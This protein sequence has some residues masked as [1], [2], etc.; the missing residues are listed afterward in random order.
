[1]ALHKPLITIKQQVYEI[2]RD[3]IC[4]GTYPPGHQL[5]ETGL[6]K[7]LGVS[8]SPIREA[9]RQL[10]A[11]GLATDFP[12]RGVFVKAYTT[13]DIKD[14]FDMRILLES[15][16]FERACANITP[17]IRDTLNSC[18]QDLRKFHDCGDLRSYI[19]IDTFLHHTLVTLCGNSL[20][21]DTY[22][23]VYAM[24]QRF[25]EYSLKSPKRFN[26]S[27]T[28]HTEI[29][30]NILDGNF[31]EANRINETHLI[32]AKEAIINYL[33]GSNS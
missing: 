6:S 32:L 14:I 2:L 17:E 21:I 29:I 33:K 10:V 20:V 3:N 26:D 15:Y 27:L 5:Q 24:I 13:K 11:E 9:L 31:K 7:E 16:A 8:R 12:N 22:D 1:M 18:T 23:R 28:E 30:H 19:E 25:R 4:N